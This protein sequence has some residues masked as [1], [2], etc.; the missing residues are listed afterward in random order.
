[1]LSYI[2]PAQNYW[3]RA[4]S[5]R[6]AFAV[7]IV[8]MAFQQKAATAVERQGSCIAGDSLLFGLTAGPLQASWGGRLTINPL[9]S[10]D[11]P[12]AS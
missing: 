6:S 1:M 8:L 3:L 2:R 10:E 7:Q 4:R 5:P 11:L 9:A 12:D